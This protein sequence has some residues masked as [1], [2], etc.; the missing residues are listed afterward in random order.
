MNPTPASTAHA[1]SEGAALAPAAP[2]K[3]S[4]QQILSACMLMGGS[5][6]INI[7]VSIVRTKVVAVLLGPA[8]FGLMGMLSAIAD[9]AH[10]LA[11]MGINNS[12][13]RQIAEAQAA[14]DTER[15]GRSAAVLRRVAWLLGLSGALLVVVLSAPIA[16]L[17]FGDE[18]HAG[19][20]ALLALAVF[21]R[22]IASGHAAV[23]QGARRIADL[24]RIG[25]WG[26]AV[27]AVA[28][29][30]IVFWL[31]EAGVAPALVASAA[32]QVL[33]VWHY[34]RRLDI[35]RVAVAWSD[36]W[37]ESRPLLQLGFAFMASGLLM[38]AASYVVRLIV[39]HNGGLES[40]GYFQAAWTLGGLYV[41][42]ILGAMSADFYPRLV[43]LATQHDQMN[44]LVNEQ[45]RVSVLLGG[46]GVIGTLILA[47]LLVPMFYSPQFAAAVDVLRWICLGMA[48]RVVSW[49]IGYVVIAKNRRALFVAVDAGWTALYLALCW[50]LV[51]KFGLVG[52]GISFLLANMFH[53]VLIA[54][55]ARRLVGFA[56]SQANA[57]LL[58]AY[59][60]CAALAWIAPYFG[61]A[62]AHLMSGAALLLVSGYAVR[63]L[64]LLSEADLVPWARLRALLKGQRT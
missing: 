29:V 60:A 32:V 28:T 48:V 31:G 23:L 7:A 40:A 50:T 46:P 54:V 5:S 24:A 8:G 61:S 38:M 41:G 9:L 15:V 6:A 4:Y 37:R 63:S 3:S 39:L 2:V 27:S 18:R 33:I 51:G 56:W 20:V 25:A 44:Q 14:G 47:P 22:L 62:W 16:R 17:S 58:L 19:A 30:L 12:G 13:V 52:A 55:V 43:G 21:L 64:V 36:T 49:P 26:A 11:S 57:R 35:S 53:L 10:S 45:T 42:F 59:A 34:A 1:T